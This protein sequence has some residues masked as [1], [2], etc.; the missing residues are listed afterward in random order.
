MTIIMDDALLEGLEQIFT[1]AKSDI[2]KSKILYE[3]NLR[4]NNSILK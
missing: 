3:R 4:V 2:K 1:A